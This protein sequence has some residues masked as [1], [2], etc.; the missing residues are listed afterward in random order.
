[1]V[2][3][4]ALPRW[5]WHRAKPQPIMEEIVEGW[6]VNETEVRTVRPIPSMPATV[7]LQMRSVDHSRK[8]GRGQCRS[9][10]SRETG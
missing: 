4:A 10:V 6:R 8:V 1:M 3:A 9:V 5:T 7:L 2:G